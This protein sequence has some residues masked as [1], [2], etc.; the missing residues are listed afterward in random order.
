MLPK[1]VAGAVLFSL[2]QAFHAQDP[3]VQGWWP[4]PWPFPLQ[5]PVMMAADG[6][7]YRVH[8]WAHEWEPLWRF[9]ALHHFPHK[10]YWLNVGRV[11]PLD[12]SLQV[13][14][15]TVPFLW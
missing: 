4:A 2:S 12:K 10:L 7:R 9:H 13:C 6:V 5:V 14:L 3:I 15:D 1:P 11:H 8:R